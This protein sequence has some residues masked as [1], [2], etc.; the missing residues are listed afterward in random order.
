M[1][2]TDLGETRIGRWDVGMVEKVATMATTNHTT[3][4]TRQ[5]HMPKT[6]TSPCHFLPLLPPITQN[7]KLSVPANP[8][9]FSPRARSPR[10]TPSKSGK[11]GNVHHPSQHCHP[12]ALSPTGAGRFRGAAPRRGFNR[13]QPAPQ[14]DTS[15]LRPL[16]WQGLRG[17]GRGLSTRYNPDDPA[18]RGIVAAASPRT[19]RSST[20]D[21][22]ACK[23]SRSPSSW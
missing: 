18:W 5:R 4:S 9:G 1:F 3:H 6:A 16:P 2:N 11:N 22:A 17:W 21:E 7:V 23:Y 12:I 15:T 8:L 19:H 10:A 14:A 20:I 13:R